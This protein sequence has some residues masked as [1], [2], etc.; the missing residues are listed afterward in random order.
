LPEPA[1]E[2][3]SEDSDLEAPPQNTQAIESDSEI[4]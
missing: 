2:E 4:S 1:F 3:E